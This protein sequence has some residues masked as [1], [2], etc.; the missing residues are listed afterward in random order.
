MEN[1]G[2]TENMEKMENMEKAP[3]VALRDE[4]NR[5]QEALDL[6][7]ESWKSASIPV[8]EEMTQATI[9]EI[10]KYTRFLQGMARIMGKY[11]E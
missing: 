7:G 9:A 1:M 11:A 10:Q 5:Y 2:N 8:I 4:I 6:L 3:F